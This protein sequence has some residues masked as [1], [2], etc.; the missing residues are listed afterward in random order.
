M[1]LGILWKLLFALF[2]GAIAYADIKTGRVPRIAFIVAFP[3]FFI[4]KLLLHEHIPAWESIAG[5]LAGLLIFLSAYYISGRKLGLADIWYSALIGLVLGPW[6]WYAAIGGACTAGIIY[7]L[8]SRRRQ[9]P[10]IP[11]MALGS[12]VMSIAHV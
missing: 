3:F 12:V 4:L 2:S 6:W 11:L 8:I 5:G 9:I 1:I 7:F 10:F